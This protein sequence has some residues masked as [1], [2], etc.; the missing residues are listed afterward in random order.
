MIRMPWTAINTN[1]KVNGGSR[2]N[3]FVGQY[4]RKNR[5]VPGIS[6]MTRGEVHKAVSLW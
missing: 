6:H 4:I 3:R 1:I 2:T 5:R